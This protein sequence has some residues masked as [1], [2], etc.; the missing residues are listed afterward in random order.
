MSERS[1]VRERNPRTSV[2]CV[3]VGVSRIPSPKPQSRSETVEKWEHDLYIEE[4]QK[5]RTQL[6]KDRVRRAERERG[7]FFVPLTMISCVSFLL[8]Q[9]NKR[10]EEWG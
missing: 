10:L 1:C 4:E 9:D 6:E 5:P 8:V 2:M 3:W 7:V